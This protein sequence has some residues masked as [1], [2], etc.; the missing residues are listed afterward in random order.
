[1]SAQVTLSANVS[2]TKLDCPNSRT[3]SDVK[4]SF[5]CVSVGREVSLAAKCQEKLMILEICCIVS[6]GFPGRR[7]TSLPKRSD[8]FSEHVSEHLYRHG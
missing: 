3:G 5:R 6:C 7:E 2:H 8:S 4:N 1:M